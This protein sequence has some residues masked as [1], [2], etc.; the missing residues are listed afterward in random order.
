MRIITSRL[1]RATIAAAIFLLP[2]LPVY[3]HR[4]PAVSLNIRFA[5]GANRFHVG[6]VIPIELSFSA[7]TAETFQMDTR[8]YDRSGRLGIEQFHVSPSGRDPLHNHYQGGIFMAFIGGGLSS[9]PKYIGSDPQILREELNEYVALDAPGHYSLFVTSGRVSRFENDVPQAV[10]LTSNTIEF[11]VVAT[12]PA[13]EEHALSSAT[14]ALDRSGASDEE[15]RV[16][17]RTLR[18][19]DS[20]QSI[21][22]AVRQLAKPGDGNRWDFV[23]S[24]IGSGHPNLVKQVLE[25]ELGSP[26]TAITNDYLS[27]LA[28]TTFFLTQGPLPPYPENDKALQKDWQQK[29]SERF[30]QYAAVQDELYERTAALLS[31]KQG[32][33]RAVTIQTLVLHP[34]PA[35]SKAQMPY[36]LSESDIASAFLALPPHQQSN[37]LQ[38]YW[39]RFNVPAMAGVLEKF[40]ETPNFSD[41]ETRSI[42]FQRL[43]ELDP[44]A[45]APLVLAEIRQPHLD[46][47]TFT[48]SAKSLSGLEATTL[49]ELDDLLATRLEKKQTRTGDLDAQLISRYATAAILRR[50]EAVNDSEVANRSCKFQDGLNTYFLRNDPDYAFKKIG[51]VSLCMPETLKAIV[52]M[53]RW[54]DVEPALIKA[55]DDPN[56]WSARSAAETLAKYGGANVEQ[57][58][59]QRVRAFHKQWAEREKDLIQRP[60]M[61][62]DANE[63][64]G[65]EF[66]LVEALGH[67]Q[68]WLLDNDQITELE[69]L[70]LGNE[71]DNVTHWHWHSPVDLSLVFVN[72]HDVRA[73]VNNAQYS[74]EDM[75]NLCAKLIQYPVGTRFLINTFGQD[76]RLKSVV[77]AISETAQAHGLTV[78]LTPAQ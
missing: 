16:A 74:A 57:A 19:M 23:A 10:A 44:K 28:E 53:K 62:R 67:S 47:G 63:A 71:R 39:D 56:L 78:D 29:Q 24:L 31:A 54:P 37:V 11:D 50:V 20:P 51:I 1:L 26:D 76:Q 61:P 77:E 49:P 55:L 36:R 60:N 43:T 33:A 69:N 15:K 48:V 34:S 73:M 2:S 17:I 30:K 5:D 21:H 9:G 66:G 59:W 18:F 22:E 52:Q 25:A 42:A 4:D 12:D 41:G 45:A 65:F 35:G 3:C 7:S 40:L 13:W 38:F 6:E 70:T 32:S 46:A 14:A 75:A 64:M 27:A 8:N 68:G 58:L 72:E